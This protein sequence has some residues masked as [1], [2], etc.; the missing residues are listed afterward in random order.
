MEQM[1]GAP[2]EAL[3]IRSPGEK[4]AFEV[5]ELQNAA[6]RI[7]QQKITY[8]EEQLIE[9]LLNQMLESARRNMTALEIVPVLDDDFAVVQFLKITPEVVNSAGTI[10][11][12]GARHFAAQAQL[13]Q[14]I[15]GMVNSA[16]YSDPSVNTHISGLKLAELMEENL[17]LDAFDIVQAN[18]RVAEQQQTQSL[19]NL[20]ADENVG[21]IADRALP[22]EAPVAEDTG[23]PLEQ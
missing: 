15:L 23:A 22:N 8:F 7:F 19:S 3:G 2:K 12:V 18:I 14:N 5:Q 9:P 17:G 21:E 16:L 11:P 1:A 13:M 4:T 6:G 20:A 10:Y